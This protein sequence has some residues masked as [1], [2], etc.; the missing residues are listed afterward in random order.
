M[1][2]E[3]VC[4]YDTGAE[5]KIVAFQLFLSMICSFQTY[6]VLDYNL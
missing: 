3:A 5:A 1:V 4:M 2:L 6:I